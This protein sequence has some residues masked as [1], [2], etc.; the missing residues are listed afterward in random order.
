LKEQEVPDMAV[1]A[2][3]HPIAGRNDEQTKKLVDGAFPA[4]LKAATEWQPAK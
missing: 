2:V 3:E 1:V 4:I